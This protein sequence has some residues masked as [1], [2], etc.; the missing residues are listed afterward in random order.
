MATTLCRFLKETVVKSSRV[1]VVFAHTL[2]QTEAL[3]SDS[4]PVE[5]LANQNDSSVSTPEGD[6]APVKI[7]RFYRANA[8][9][10]GAIPEFTGHALGLEQYEVLTKDE[11]KDVYS[12]GVIHMTPQFGQ[13][14]NPHVIPSTKEKRLIACL[15]DEDS[16]KLQ[17]MWLHKGEPQ[18]CLC[19]VFF[20]LEEVDAFG[21]PK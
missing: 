16:N 18:R 19:G 8:N 20:R 3:K 4:V 9:L 5:K 12:T 13:I 21:D 11:T 17:Y 6:R 7:D 1:P 15:C 14:E 10:Q 2:S